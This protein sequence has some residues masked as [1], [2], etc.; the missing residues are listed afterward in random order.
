MCIRDRLKYYE[1]FLDVLVIDKND[2]C[3][4]NTGVDVLKT[5]IMIKKDRDSKRLALFLK[6]NIMK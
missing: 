1:E 2:K 3:P 6:R 5:D 4:V